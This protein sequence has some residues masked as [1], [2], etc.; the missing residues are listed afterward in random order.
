MPQPVLTEP[1]S[2]AAQ[3]DPYPTYAYLRTHQPVR[4][5]TL[6]NG[7]GLWLITRYDDIERALRDPRLVKDPRNACTPDQLAYFPEEAKPLLEHMLSSD[8]PD[9]TRLRALVH[10]AFSP[11]LVERLRPRIQQIADEL[12]DAAQSRGR[13]A[14]SVRGRWTSLTTTRSPCQSLS[15]PSY[16][17]CPRGTAAGSAIGPRP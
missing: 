11:H 1:F 10:K 14:P 3:S 5:L 4:R 6:P 12:L 7:Q 15:S 2:P 8:P 16:S 9:H 13:G 17:G